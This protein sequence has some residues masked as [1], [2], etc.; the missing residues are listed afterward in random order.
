MAQIEVLAGPACVAYAYDACEADSVLSALRGAEMKRRTFIK[1]IFG[2]LASVYAPA[3]LLGD[4]VREVAK[5]VDHPAFW[6]SGDLTPTK[7]ELIQKM[8]RALQHAHAQC[9]MRDTLSIV[10]TIKLRRADTMMHLAEQLGDD[11]GNPCTKGNPTGIP[12]ASVA[13]T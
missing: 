8:R 7:E 12:F 10:E 3:V 9:S 5:K 1:A 11:L 2:V 6:R 13:Y 4:H